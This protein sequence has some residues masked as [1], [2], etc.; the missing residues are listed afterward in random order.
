[1][2]VQ[3]TRGCAVQWGMVST[4]GRISQIQFKDIMSALRGGC[5]VHQGDIMSTPDIYH[6]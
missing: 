6:N 4:L 5:S 2:P 3:Y 1:M